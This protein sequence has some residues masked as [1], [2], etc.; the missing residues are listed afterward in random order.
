MTA[1]QT[2]KTRVNRRLRPK[3][4]GVEEARSESQ[5]Q[6]TSLKG[7]QQV[8]G[9]LGQPVSVAQRWAM[10]GMPVAREGRF[11]T[12][13]PKALADWLGRDSSAGPVHVVT[14]QTDL[15]AELKRGVTYVRRER[16]TGRKSKS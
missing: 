14:P 6:P 13:P 15:L 10:T 11:V 9:F 3:K 12:A 8:A 2:M 4:E 7:W 1:K 5:P 16:S